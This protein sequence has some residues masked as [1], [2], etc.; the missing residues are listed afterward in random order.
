MLLGG[1]GVVAGVHALCTGGTTA[2]GA[3]KWLNLSNPLF[4]AVGG[5]AVI[6]TACGI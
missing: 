6:R 1:A 4:F 3:H 2:D 5:A